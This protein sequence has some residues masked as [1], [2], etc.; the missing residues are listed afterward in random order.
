MDNYDYVLEY[1]LEVL[2][3]FSK[4]K[5]FHIIEYI[6]SYL[7]FLIFLAIFCCS[8]SVINRAQFLF[9]LSLSCAGTLGDE[10]KE[11]FGLCSPESAT[12]F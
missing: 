4:I 3:S 11:M 1:F 8:Y 6:L 5:M 12:N 9:S 10:T 7:K 2:A